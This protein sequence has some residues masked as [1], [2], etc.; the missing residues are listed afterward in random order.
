METETMKTMLVLNISPELEDDLVDYLLAQEHVTGFT[1]YPVRGH[2]EHSYLSIA[3]QVSGRRKRVQFEL[4]MAE[5][6]VASVISKLATEVGIGIGYW[7]LPVSNV[8]RV[9]GDTARH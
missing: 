5:A 3:E 7:Q 9:T 6:E 8:G 2:G 4:I 1:S